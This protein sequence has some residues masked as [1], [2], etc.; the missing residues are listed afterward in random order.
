MVALWVGTVVAALYVVLFHRELLRGE[1]QSAASTSIVIAGGV[2]LLLGCVRGFTLVP[3]TVLVVV[4][5]PF[6]AP[7]TLLLLTLAGI[8]V[9]AANIYWFSRAL[10]IDDV[11]VPRHARHVVRLQTALARYEL[12]V[13]VGWSFFPLVPTDVIGYV[14]GTLRVNFAKY[15]V[16]IA[17]GEGT[18]C[19]LYIFLG[20]HAMRFLAPQ[21]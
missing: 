6:F 20:A 18:I 2:Y 4:A 19:A 5:I 13:I 21:I 15:L 14:C 10:H 9:S 3:A 7:I 16:G 1:L 11:L 8:L 17:I 12:P